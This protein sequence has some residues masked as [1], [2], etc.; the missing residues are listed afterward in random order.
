[1]NKQHKPRLRIW[2][3]AQRRCYQRIKTGLT[4]HQNE[5]L[6]FLTLGSSPNMKRSQQESFRALKERLNRTSLLK[7]V[8]DGYISNKQLRTH[9]ANK[10]LGYTPV[11][12]YIAVRTDEGPHGVLHI[13]Y[14]GDFI[15]QAWLKQTW[16]DL[17]GSCQSVYIRMCKTPTYDEHRLARYCVDQYC[18]GQT[19]Y[20]RYST[21]KNWV[22]PGFVHHYNRL[23]TYCK[24]FNHYLGECYGHPV[25]ALD[26]VQLITKWEQWLSLH[27][28]RSFDE[29]LG[30]ESYSPLETELSC[31]NFEFM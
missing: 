30:I 26:M 2:S 18:V 17:T 23:R 8:R 12:D 1:M 10:P 9:Y 27:G 5:I 15:P 29:Y 21:S 14:F 6:R 3:T 16:L 25:Y 24:D 4:W 13:L 22:Y 31:H 11:F 19:E 20:I 7:L 28:S